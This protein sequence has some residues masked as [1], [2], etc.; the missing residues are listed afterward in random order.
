MNEVVI[1]FIA[2]GAVLPII[3]IGAWALLFKVPLDEKYKAYCRILLAGLTAYALAKLIGSIFQPEVQRPFELLGVE[4]GASFLNNPGFPSDHVLFCVAI[5]LAV[6]FE[7]RQK[8]LTV[9]L[10]FLTILVAAGRVFALVHTPLD[11]FGGAVI[12]GIGAVWY[13]QRESISRPGQT[14]QW[15]KPP[16][17][18]KIS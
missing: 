11:V 10:A 15:S 6:W 12:A 13:L 1:K 8:T 5:T 9:I 2:D 17:A 3:L 4:A 14:R 16:K 18:G 7:T